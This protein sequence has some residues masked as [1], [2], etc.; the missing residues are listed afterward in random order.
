MSGYK[1]L[2][3]SPQGSRPSSVGGSSGLSFE[4]GSFGAYWW[5][6]TKILFWVGVV[7]GLLH[8]GHQGLGGI[9]AVLA[10]SAVLAPI[11]ALFWASIFWVFGKLF[12]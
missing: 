6:A 10:M 5:A 9:L 12:G 11:K 2:F 3:D 1:S 8:Y 7:L 4:P